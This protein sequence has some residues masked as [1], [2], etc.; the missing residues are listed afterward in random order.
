MIFL[1]LFWL[2][3]TPY[4]ATY[5][6]IHTPGLGHYFPFD[7]RVRVAVAA[8]SN[9]SRPCSSKGTR[10][11]ELCTTSILSAAELSCDSSGPIPAWSIWVCAQQLATEGDASELAHPASW[12][13]LSDGVFLQSGHRKEARHTVRSTQKITS[14]TPEGRA[15]TQW[16]DGLAPRHDHQIRLDGDVKHGC[17]DRPLTEGDDA[18]DG[19]LEATLSAE[20]LQ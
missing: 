17:Q 3:G 2:G 8:A 18:V 12:N 14:S 6:G 16:L 11:P 7:T 9:L 1:P 13:E 10:C 4:S 5:Y 20:L 15:A 19:P